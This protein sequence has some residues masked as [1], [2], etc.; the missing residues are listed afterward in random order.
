M[1]LARRYSLD[2]VGMSC[3][4]IF[5]SVFFLE[6]NEPGIRVGTLGIRGG[7]IGV[8]CKKY[9]NLTLNEKSKKVEFDNSVIVCVKDDQMLITL[10]KRL[11][12][13]F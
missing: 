9:K 8:V 5:G 13:V 6:A 1:T 11:V 2:G 10:K 7:R 12:W 3:H 4:S